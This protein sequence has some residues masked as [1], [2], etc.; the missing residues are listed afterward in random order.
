MSRSTR[1]RTSSGHSSAAG[2]QALGGLGQHPATRPARG[3][4]RSGRSAASPATSVPYHRSTSRKSSGLSSWTHRTIFHVRLAHMSIETSIAAG[5]RESRPAL[6]LPPRRAGRAGLDPLPG[7]ARRHRR[8]VG[9]AQWQRAHC[10]KNI[11]QLREL[12]GD[13]VD[14]RFY[15]DLERDQAERATMSMLVPPQMINTMVPN[16]APSGPGSLTD[17]FYADP[18]RRYM[19]PVFSDRRTDWPS[20]PTP[21]ATRCTSTTC[22]S[23]RASPTATPPRC[24]PSCCPPAR[25]TAATAPG[26]TWSATPPPVVEKLKFDAKPV[27]RLDAMLDY[28]RRTPACATSS[29]PAATWP[30]CRG[31]GSRRSST[32]CSRSRTSATSGWRPRR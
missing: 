23:P 10:V 26:W 31:R 6:R 27:D 30:T 32:G 19:L 3:A 17:A 1:I 9:V 11:K 21:P 12:L 20:T 8:A 14:E 5:I 24:S 25:S 2:V 13:L 28:L 16:V 7:L 18:I 15:A 22:G 4:A 29:S